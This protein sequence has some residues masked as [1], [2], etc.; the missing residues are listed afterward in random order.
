M[1]TYR[2]IVT[3]INAA[4]PWLE[5]HPAQSKFHYAV[6]KVLKTCRK[7]WADYTEQLEELDID[8]CAVGKDDVILK[9]QRGE[10]QF[11]KDGLRKRN[12][13]RKELFESSVVVAAFVKDPP[14]DLAPFER[15]AFEGF[16]LAEQIPDES[17][18]D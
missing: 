18:S 6:E 11:T 5:K 16:V 2:E 12:A 14:D 7:L 1:K 3:F 8:H 9:D 17:G 15:E 4:V 13:A 10:L